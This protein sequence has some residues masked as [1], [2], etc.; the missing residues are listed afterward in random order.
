MATGT[1][2]RQPV[3][4]ATR[5]R[6]NNHVALI[7]QRL[8][9]KDPGIQF[10]MT[11]GS[12]VVALY[13]YAGIMHTFVGFYDTMDAHE[14]MEV[15]SKVEGVYSVYYV[16]AIGFGSGHAAARKEGQS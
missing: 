12:A 10:V 5:T 7:E 13:N 1:Y 2:T 8:P 15:V 4:K 6:I 11:G 14:A 16:T 9:Y 3:S